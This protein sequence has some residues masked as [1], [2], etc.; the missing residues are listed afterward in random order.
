MDRG[1]WTA[2]TVK[3]PRQQPAHPQ[4]ANYWAPLTRKRHIPP[5]AAQPQHTNYW[6]PRTRKR[7]QQE[8]RPQRPTERSDPT[9]HAKGRTGDRPGPRKGATT[10]R[11]V[12]QGGLYCCLFAQ[13]A[14]LRCEEQE[15]HFEDLLQQAKARL[16]ERLQHD[17]ERLR[18]QGSE[19]RLGALEVDL[20]E[21]Q[22]ICKKRGTSVAE[23]D[24]R[25][26]VAL[27]EAT[28]RAESPRSTRSG[29][30]PLAAP[31]ADDPV[32]LTSSDDDTRARARASPLMAPVDGHELEL[33]DLEVPAAELKP[34]KKRGAA[35]AKRPPQ[36]LLDVF[37]DSP[38]SSS[39][40]SPMCNVDL[41]G[42]HLEWAIGLIGD[43]EE[44]QIQLI[45][46]EK[47]KLQKAR[48]LL[49]SQ[50]RE[51]KERQ[52]VRSPDPTPRRKLEVAGG[53]VRW[54]EGAWRVLDFC[55]R[56]AGVARG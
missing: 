7:H 30:P 38:T 49:K 53:W 54:L 6:A 24:L 25:S 23:L 43:S 31:V 51:L 18:R 29:K 42:P 36:M 47:V 13:S 50:K 15:R 21:S 52:Q 45:Q 37:A 41:S 33:V 26:S 5:H 27:S 20:R 14:C 1:V 12:T 46:E 17:E 56:L 10:R 3:R 32:R 44:K 22:R 4:C 28:V 9:Q 55:W 16:E 39:S 2:K 40:D 34:A 19:G 8:H 35:P 48:A 11:N